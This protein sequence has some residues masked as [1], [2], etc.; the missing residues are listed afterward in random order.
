MR[1]IR[2]IIEYDGTE[3]VGWQVQP[4][5]IAVQEAV[6]RELAK[7]T[8]ERCAL[9]ASGRTDSGVMRLRRS[10]ISTHKAAFPQTSSL[11]R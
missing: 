11:S 8:G 5:G 2:L 6:E 4:N 7:L 3:Y 1:R 10:P 9:H